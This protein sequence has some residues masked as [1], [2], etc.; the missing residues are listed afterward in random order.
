MMKIF[1]IYS[2]YCCF[3]CCGGVYEEIHCP[4]LLP[5]LTLSAL[6]VKLNEY[7]RAVTEKQPREQAFQ[8]MSMNKSEDEHSG[9]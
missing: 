7:W 4:S 6:G 5:R 9:E 8:A 2:Y 1:T 3:C